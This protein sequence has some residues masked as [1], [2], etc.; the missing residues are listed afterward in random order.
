MSDTIFHKIIRKEIP[1]EMLHEDEHCIAIRD[2]HPVG[3]VHI[4]VIP[5]KTLPGLSDAQSDD[6]ELLGH[7]LLTATKLAQSEGLTAA[8]YRV[9][10]NS[11][12]DGGQ[13]VGQLHIHLV[14]GRAFGWPPG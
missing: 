6:K 11:G 7:L 14:G 1:A 8:G 3:P 5:K 12:E 9:V 10:V 2:I 4:L 13:T